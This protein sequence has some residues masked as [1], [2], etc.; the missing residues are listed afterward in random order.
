MGAPACED[1]RRL[2]VLAQYGSAGDPEGRG[3]VNKCIPFG[4]ALE[5]GIE[6]TGRRISIRGDAPSI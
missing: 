6:I 5:S 1:R 4:K 2:R 3:A